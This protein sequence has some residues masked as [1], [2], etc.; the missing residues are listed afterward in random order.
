MSGKEKMQNGCA[1]AFFVVFGL[2]F[3]IIIAIGTGDSKSSSHPFALIVGAIAIGCVLIAVNW[4]NK[5]D[6]N[7]DKK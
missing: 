7:R 6:P 3:L 5:N 4:M 1:I 2:S